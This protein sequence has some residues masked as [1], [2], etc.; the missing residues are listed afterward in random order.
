MSMSISGSSMASMTKTISH[1]LF[2]KLDTKKQGYIDKSELQ[3][4]F[5]S[6]SG[7][8]DTSSTDQLFAKLDGNSDGKI[9]ESELSTGM[10]SLG[11]ALQ[12]QLRQSQASGG[13]MPM[14]P[15]PG[16]DAGG[17]DGMTKDQITSIAN[18]SS[19][20]STAKAKLTALAKNFDAAD[21]NQD[22]KV[23]AK[24]AMA[25]DQSQSAKSTD[26][27]SG[28]NSSSAVD[29]QMKLMAQLMQL[30]QAYGGDASGSSSSTSSTV[31][32]TA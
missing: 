4:A 29:E 25:F 15:P 30:I 19:T 5:S 2:S 20:D 23:S 14:G 26:S 28:S 27:A 21:T 16:M 10:Q 9:T 3:Q 11:E 12:S 7:S 31:S 32:A 13:G 8:S 24:E 1:D 6:I 18:D 17:S 22:G